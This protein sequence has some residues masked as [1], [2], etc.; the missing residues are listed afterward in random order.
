MSNPGVTFEDIAS[1]DTVRTGTH[2]YTCIYMDTLLFCVFPHSFLRY[3]LLCCGLTAAAF[4]ACLALTNRI[5]AKRVLQEAVALPLLIPD[6]FTGLRRPWRGILLFGPP[7]TG[8]TLLA[9]AVATEYK[10]TF[11]NVDAATVTSK[12]RGDSSRL[13]RILFQMHGIMRHRRFSLM[14]WTRWPASAPMAT[15][16]R[17]GRA[18]VSC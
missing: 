6:F 9:K 8:K 12:F 15:T 7:G 16:K 1:L 14:K 4:C 10:T 17:V 5:Q 2:M 13:M 3:K 11:F 18:R